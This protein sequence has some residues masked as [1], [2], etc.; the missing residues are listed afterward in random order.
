MGRRLWGTT[1]YLGELPAQLVARQALK[2]RQLLLIV[3]R[4]DQAEAVPVGEQLLDGVPDL[5]APALIAQEHSKRG[6]TVPAVA[7]PAEAQM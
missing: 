2:L 5:H 6:G 1:A 3:V 4:P 7:T